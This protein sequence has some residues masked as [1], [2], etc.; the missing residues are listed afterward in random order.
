MREIHSRPFGFCIG[1]FILDPLHPWNLNKGCQTHTKQP[2]PTSINHNQWRHKAQSCCHK[3]MVK[4]R[5]YFLCNGLLW[6]IMVHNYTNNKRITYLMDACE[7]HKN[8]LGNDSKSST[9]W[10]QHISLISLLMVMVSLLC[11][12]EWSILMGLK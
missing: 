12:W 7:S 11:S 10:Y 9:H 3:M 4:W 2:Q 8:I 6:F 5:C 1:N